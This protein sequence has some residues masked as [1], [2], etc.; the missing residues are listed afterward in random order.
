M[1]ISHLFLCLSVRSARVIVRVS[2]HMFGSFFWMQQIRFHRAPRTSPYEGSLME[3]RGRQ[4]EAESF[5]L[6]LT[7]LAPLGLGAPVQC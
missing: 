1:H 2:S 6:L 4:S 7:C 5:A 3:S